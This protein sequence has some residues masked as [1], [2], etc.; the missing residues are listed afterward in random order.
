MNS[1]LLTTLVLLALLL[2]MTGCDPSLKTGGGAGGSFCRIYE[3]IPPSEG[4]G[5]IIQRNEIAYCALCA[6]DCPKF[7]LDE[8]EKRRSE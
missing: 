6:S 3:P 7:I 1:K 4:S 5:D 8:W 2:L